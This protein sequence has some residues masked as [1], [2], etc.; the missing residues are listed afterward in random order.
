MYQDCT[1]GQKIAPLRTPTTGGS[2]PAQLRAGIE[3]ST[4]PRTP[5]A[6]LDLFQ[7][8]PVVYPILYPIPYSYLSLLFKREGVYR[9]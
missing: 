2:Y 9:V 1:Y 3:E 8:F 6:P 5:Y 7:L 4:D